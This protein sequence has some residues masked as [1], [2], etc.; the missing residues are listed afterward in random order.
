MTPKR[1]MVLTWGAILAVL[2]GTAAMDG[3]RNCEVP[4]NGPFR[5]LLK[6]HKY[7]EARGGRFACVEEK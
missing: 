1:W 2:I 7:V 3:G 5:W 4:K 6:G